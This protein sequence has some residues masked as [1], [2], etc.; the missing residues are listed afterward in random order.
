MGKSCSGKP[1]GYRVPGGVT[2]GPLTPN[3]IQVTWLEF[4][5][6]VEPPHLP[7]FNPSMLMG[8]PDHTLPGS[9]TPLPPS[10]GWPLPLQ[11]AARS[12]W[13]PGQGWIQ[14]LP[15]ALR[16]APPAILFFRRR[17]HR[18]RSTRCPRP[19][20]LVA[21]GM[22][23]TRAAQAAGVGVVPDPPEPFAH[24]T[25]PTWISLNEL[26]PWARAPSGG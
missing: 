23:Q 13:A 26:R 16:N 22:P 10:N 5:G 20:L 12:S 24:R 21:E 6:P 25:Q 3:H 9:S 8:A 4:G 1:P 17:P 11:A 7:S 2:D 18:L 14:T 15:P 19:P